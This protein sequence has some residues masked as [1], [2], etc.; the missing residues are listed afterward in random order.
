M[1]NITQIPAPRVPLIETNTGLMTTQ[2]FRY[3]NNINI[4]VGGGTGVTPT[5]S[6]GTGTGVAPL[7]GQILIGNNTGAYTVAYL[8]AGTGLFQTPGDG[9]LAVGISNTTVTAGAYGS[10]SA[11][12]TFTVNPQ[13]QLTSAVS[14]AISISTSQITSG[15][16]T[17][18][19]GGTNGSATPTS[20]AI[21]YGTGTAYA[22]SAAG[23]TNQILLSGGASS[24][25]WANQS[26][27][28][29]GTATNL[30]GGAAGSL[31]YQVS[32]GS[33]TFLATG[34]NGQ[35]LTLTAGVPSWSTPSA[36]TVTSVTGTAPVVSSGGNT[37]VISMPAATT[38]VSGYL[39][40]TDWT[41]FNNKQPAGTYVTSVGATSPVTSS[42][43]TTPTIAIPAATTSVS[44]Y[45]T[46]TDW[47]T[48]NNKGSGTV[49]SVSGTAPVVSSGGATPAI[50]M[51]AATT[52]VSGYLTSTDWTTFN[53]KGNG[54]V[55]SV[56]ALTLG[57]TGTDLSSSVATGT[58]TPVITLNVPTASASNR[59]ALSA[60]DWTTFNNK[61]SGTVSSVSFTGGL[62]T[63]ATATTTPALTVAGTSGGVVYFSSASTW[64]S[65]AALTLNSL[66]IGG[67][68]GAAPATTATGTGVL[69]ALGT[70]IG[71]AGSFVLNGGALGTPSSGTVTNLTGTAS[72]NIN[73]TV[74]A[75]TPS[76][77]VFT[78]LTDSGL[79][80]GRVNYNGTGGLL[81]D[82]A[83]LTFDGT[84]ATLN[85][86]LTLTNASD[87]NLYSSGAGRNFMSASLGIGVAAPV[88]TKLRISG[89][90]TLTGVNIFG[91]DA[92][93]T[94]P[95]TATSSAY[96]YRSVAFTAAAAFTVPDL[97]HFAA[98]QST[99]GASSAVTNQYGFAVTS[100]L[101][102]ATNNYG[103]Y[104]SLASS[105]G[106]YNFYAAGTA[107]NYMAGNLGVTGTPDVNLHVANSAAKLRLGLTASNQFLDIYRENSTGFSIY[108]AAQTTFSAHIFQIATAEYLR[109]NTSG[110]I[111]LA[112]SVGAHSLQVTPVASSVNYHQL[113]GAA[114]GAAVVHSALGT[115]ANINLSFVP[116]GTGTMQFGTY[117]AGT[118]VQTGYIT[119]TDAGGTSR[120]LLVG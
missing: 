96:G 113:A 10:A 99:I 20:G 80:A 112:G 106:R 27:L 73:G 2:W 100:S 75:T 78:T 56:A 30:A 67:G 3:F 15:L 93:L 11:V 23:T 48:F 85:G 25:T 111:T 33:T 120:R 87:Y 13:G 16:L 108:N 66:M 72:I 76:T 45:L 43:G 90:S 38:S 19:R 115:D 47:N 59:G 51:T 82:S 68:A 40:N 9:S 37:P 31:P 61:G 74:G 70:N 77:G 102:G 107:D 63:V 97:Y 94:V 117:T 46:S 22:F 95:S 55:T 24:P 32:S 44:G 88:S 41:T 84:T 6:G 69:T 60:A 28:A 103:F 91:V 26:S 29:V 39:T 62:I 98:V 57:T 35:V 71:T 49:T 1:P 58:T 53:N 7:N 105:T 89:S 65:S 52:S 110:T 86:Q 118:V 79:T 5:T 34:S 21:S 42:G 92:Q 12:S 83:N 4:I 50:S 101:T 81:V 14:V 36:G 116:K 8:T 119:I 104:S 54:T 109:I 114:T 17:I 64:A 18:A